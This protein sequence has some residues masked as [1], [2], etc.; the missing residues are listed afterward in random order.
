MNTVQQLQVKVNKSE[1]G[2][3]AKSLNHAKKRT[4]RR[5]NAE[6][7]GHDLDNFNEVNKNGVA[8]MSFV[9]DDLEVG[10]KVEEKEKGAQKGQ[11]SPDLAV[12]RG[13]LQRGR[14]EQSSGGDSTAH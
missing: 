7:G 8:D 9:V 5:G 6:P 1:D 2:A 12:L 14:A 11:G 4:K 3:E 10:D 13:R